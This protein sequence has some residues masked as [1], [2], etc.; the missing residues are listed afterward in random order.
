MTDEPWRLSTL[1]AC[2]G[3][4]LARTR[5]RERRSRR[6]GRGDRAVAPPPGTSNRGAAVKPLPRTCITAD[7]AL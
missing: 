2:V 1:L 3:Q 4:R 5:D 6:E 7:P